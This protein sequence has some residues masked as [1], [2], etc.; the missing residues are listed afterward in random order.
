MVILYKKSKQS[1]KNQ[2]R[3]EVKCGKKPNRL[4]FRTAERIERG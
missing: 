1:H 3:K 2:E 4:A